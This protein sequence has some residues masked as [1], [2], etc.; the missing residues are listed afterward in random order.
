MRW[1]CPQ[2]LIEQPGMQ[3][4][5]LKER[6][7]PDPHRIIAVELKYIGLIEFREFDEGTSELGDFV[8]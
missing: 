8:L 5:H 6:C 4:N 3:E 7:P 1:F 2:E